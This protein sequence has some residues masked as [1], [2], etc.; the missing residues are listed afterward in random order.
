[1]SL[2]SSIGRLADRLEDKIVNE[3]RARAK[4]E[5]ETSVKGERNPLIRDIRARLARNQDARII[6]VGESGVGKSTLALDLG[7]ILNPEL[8]VEKIDIAVEKAISF[9][10]LQ[11]MDSTTLPNRSLLDFDEPGQGW[12][13]RQFMSQASQILAQTFIGNRFQQFISVLTVPTLALLDVDA[14]RLTHYLIK[15]EKQGM[16]VVY[17]QLP[18]TFG[19]EPFWKTMIDH[20]PFEKPDTKLWHLY[21]K[22]KVA[23]QTALYAKFR[24]E[25]VEGEVP[26]LTNN[27]IADLISIEPQRYSKDGELH[28]AIIQSEFG[29]GINRAYVVKQ[30][31]T[32]KIR[33]KA[34]PPVSHEH[35]SK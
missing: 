14:V 32:Q 28:H 30:L 13:H 23:F 20:M 8:Y 5:S 25:L 9:S 34:E 16:A 12:F 19:G 33:L 2:T 10:A 35:P 11:F 24:K 7:E 21:E 17:R 3:D 4:R 31:A 15:V 27:E 6:V 26:R 29:I 22:K 1:L 18:Q